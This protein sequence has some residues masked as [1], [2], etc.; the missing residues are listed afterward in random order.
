M[1]LESGQS[2][3]FTASTEIFNLFCW[4]RPISDAGSDWD[5]RPNT[6]VAMGQIRSELQVMRWRAKRI[7]A[8]K[9]LHSSGSQPWCISSRIFCLR[10]A[11]RNI[12]TPSLTYCKYYREAV[13]RNLVPSASFPTSTHPCGTLFACTIPFDLRFRLLCFR[14]F[15][16]WT[17]QAYTR[18]SKTWGRWVFRQHVM[19]RIVRGFQMLI[20][21][22]Q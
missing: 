3:S 10:A 1:S 8:M 21:Y 5:L 11:A 4:W 19:S 20:I 22:I 7:R 16:V 15:Y 6:E 12:R 18:R 13:P 14:R 17:S 2:I 9:K